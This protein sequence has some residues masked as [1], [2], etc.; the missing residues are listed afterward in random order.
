MNQ[1][2]DVAIVTGG[3]R[4]IGRAAAT[5]LAADGVAV[6]VV[7]RTESEVRRTAE[8]INASGGRAAAVVGDVTSAGAEIIGAAER[9]LGG[10]CG[11]LV[12][13]AGTAGPVG[14]AE[15]LDVAGWRATL[16]VNVT[17]PFLL[18]RTVLPG[19][20]A[21]GAGRIVNVISGLAHR[22]QPGLA[23]YC[24]SK[25]ALLHLTRVIDAET[26]DAGVRAFAVEPGLVRTEMTRSL[27]AMDPSGVRGAVIDMLERL[28][29]DPGFVEPEESARLIRLV[30]TG[31]ADDLAGDA[32]SIY[33]PRI[34]D[35]LAARHS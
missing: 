31:R 7:A 27:L 4:G 34:R 10:P 8:E 19:M 14:A 18:A 13:A 35:R 24:A 23:A 9:R 22:P 26:R 2:H 25:A 6:A 1:Q 5:A 16:D 12:N 20:K 33:D 11:I 32:C 30:A 29:T 15:E 28:D 17:G 21:R 3:G